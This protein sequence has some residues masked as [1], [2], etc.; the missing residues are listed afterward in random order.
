MSATFY[1]LLKYAATGQASPSMTYYDRLRAST[2]MSGYPERTVTGEPPLIYD[3]KK[4]GYLTAWEIS[5]NGV[6]NG[7]PSPSSIVPFDGSGSRTGNLCPDTPYKTNYSINAN[8]VETSTT[9]FCI[10]RI[11]VNV[12]TEYTISQK[13]HTGGTH[14]RIHAYKS[15][16]WQE[17]IAAVPIQNLPSTFTTISDCDEIRI[18]I[19]MTTVPMLNTG[20]TALPYEPYG[21]KITPTIT[22]GTDSTTT[23]IYLGTVET[24]RKIKKLVLDGT[25]NWVAQGTT[26]TRTVCALRISDSINVVGKCTHIDWKDSYSSED[27]RVTLY[28]NQIFI[29]I[30]NDIL[31]E[32]TA[33]GFKAWLADEYA[34]G[35]P[36]CIWYVLST[37]QTG[38]TNEPLY[39]IGTYADAIA[40]TNHG[41]P[42]IPVL[43]GQNTLSFSET[44]QPSSVTITGEIKPTT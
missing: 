6:Q 38:I 8:G 19:T 16:M 32:T 13:E 42:Q 40:S 35:T 26:Q 14:V 31:S 27:N 43:R 2:L 15:G 11:P 22:S 17:Q 36:V 5:G 44:V 23:P 37:E 4:E 30:E 18:S 1:D 24:V 25:E 29:S 21:Y 12:N 10:Y 41:A 20:Q 3:A 33:A 7:T 34:N 9:G 28:N 39:R